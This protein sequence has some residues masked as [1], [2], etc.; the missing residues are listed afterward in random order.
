VISRSSLRRSRNLKSAF[1]LVELLVVIAIIGMLV[2]L[3]LPGVSAVRESARRTHCTNNMRNL[4]LAVHGYLSNNEEFPP[5]SQ[6]RF[7]GAFG[8]NNLPDPARHSMITF[9][10]PYFEQSN[11]FDRFDMKFDWNDSK[12]SENNANS[13][14]HLGGILICPSA[15]GGRANKH[16][17]DYNAANRVDP[18]GPIGNLIRSGAVQNRAAGTRSPDFGNWRPEWDGIMQRDAMNHAANCKNRCRDRR[19]VRVAHVKDGLSNTFMLF[20]NAGKPVCY[21]NGQFDVQCNEGSNITRFRW[22]SSNLYMRIDD[23]CAGGRMLNCSNNSQPYAFHNLGANFVLGDAAVRFVDEG[24]DPN[25]FISLFTL[26]GGEVATL[27]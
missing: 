26:A 16:V 10:L 25:T 9:L 13:R 24:I 17:S 23:V 22:A 19:T 8:R 1:T 6:F 2:S 7:G 3:L 18:T 20:E 4:G 15:P 21:A 5:A 14:Q 12:Y 11:V 27:D